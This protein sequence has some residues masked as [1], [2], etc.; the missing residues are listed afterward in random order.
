MESMTTP[1][2][3]LTIRTRVFPFVPESGRETDAELAVPAFMVP[4]LTSIA[5]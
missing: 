3:Q 2:F 1:L 5:T 4:E